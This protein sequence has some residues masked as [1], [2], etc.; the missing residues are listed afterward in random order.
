[1]N[2]TLD[3]INENY[4]QIVNSSGTFTEKYVYHGNDLV[5]Q[6]TTDGLKQAVHLDNKGSNT[7]VTDASG[8][9]VE[10]NF[11]SPFGESLSTTNSRFT[12]E[13]KEFDKAVQDMDFHFRKY[14]PSIGKF[15]Q[16]DTLI[17]NVYDPQS[18]NR[19]SFERNNPFFYVDKDGH[20][21]LRLFG[22]GVATTAGGILISLS[23][24][25]APIIG[26]R[27]VGWGITTLTYASVAPNDD[28]TA[29]EWADFASG[30][31]AKFDTKNPLASAVLKWST[32]FTT[33]S[34]TV[35]G[36][37][38]LNNNVAQ[39]FI[40]YLNERI[41]QISQEANK[42]K[43]DNKASNNNGNSRNFVSSADRSRASS[44]ISS[45]Q[46]SGFIT[47]SSGF[48]RLA[49]SLGVSVSTS[50]NNKK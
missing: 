2:Y 45:A 23:D 12:Y 40:N 14:K 1:M 48:A 27:E 17:P 26:G 15:M 49:S 32:T 50:N 4:I 18:L 28:K 43:D 24:P 16:P 44:Q 39:P 37:K 19:Y 30:G 42:A 34:Y 36:L 46:S 21:N 20:F 31:Y 9:V 8:N 29:D 25:Y 10:N 47:V 38:F 33:S 11:Y 7:L 22:L 35:T 5:A 13:A 3:Y 41:T 6:V